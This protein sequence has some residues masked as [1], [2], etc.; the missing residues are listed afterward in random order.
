MHIW[1]ASLSTSKKFSTS[2][3]LLKNLH[4]AVWQKP[5]LYKLTLTTQ[6]M[7]I[8]TWAGEGNKNQNPQQKTLPTTSKNIELKAIYFSTD[9]TFWKLFKK[10]VSPICWTYSFFQYIFT[11]NACILPQAMSEIPIPSFEKTHLIWGFG[12]CA[13]LVFF[14]TYLLQLNSRS[15]VSHAV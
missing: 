13:C 14:L 10:D 8:G 6:K 3:D 15:S 4:E 7:G 11:H 2:F 5:L 9:I 1:V 12:V